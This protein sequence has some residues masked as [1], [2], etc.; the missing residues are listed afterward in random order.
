LEFDSVRGLQVLDVSNNNIDSLPPKLGL[1]GTESHGSG[2]SALRRLEVAG[3]SF[4]VPRWEIV[5][6]GTEAVLEWLKKK[7]SCGRAKRMGK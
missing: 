5:A 2:G 7:S 6:K 1:L 3:N 4:R